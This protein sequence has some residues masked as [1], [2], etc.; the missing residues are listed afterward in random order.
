[1][2][3]KLL[4]LFKIANEINDKEEG[5]YVQIVYSADNNKK[6]DISIVSKDNYSYIEKCSVMLAQKPIQKLNVVIRLLEDYI[7][8]PIVDT[9]NDT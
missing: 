3:E 4:E 5:I 2:E 1:M 6:L 7:K 9:D 8:T